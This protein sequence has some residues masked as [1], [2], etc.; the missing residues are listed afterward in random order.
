MKEEMGTVIRIQ[1]YAQIN[2]FEVKSS[3]LDIKANIQVS[4][5]NDNKMPTLSITMTPTT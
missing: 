1:H 4:A 2:N 5:A 3:C